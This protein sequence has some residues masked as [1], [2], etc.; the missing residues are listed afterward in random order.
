MWVRGHDPIDTACRVCRLT[1]ESI[2]HFAEC[3]KMRPMFDAFAHLASVDMSKATVTEWRRFALFAL[4]P[5]GKMAEGWIN[6]HLLLWKQCVYQLTTVSTE[7]AT[8]SSHEV[9]QAAWA[10]F[11]RKALAKQEHIRTILLRAE[12]RGIEPPDVI[13]KA[14][15]LTP[16]ATITPEGKVVF[17]ESIVQQIKTLGTKPPKPTRGR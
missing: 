11:E 7:D 6:M 1:Q 10:R 8:F 3:E 14:S 16:L 2:E 15:P 9:W 12:S 5:R 17:D 13:K 4:P